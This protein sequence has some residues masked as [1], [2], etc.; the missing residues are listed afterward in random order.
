MQYML[1]IYENEG[2]WERLS[3]DQREARTGAY[4]AFAESIVKSGQ[5]KA[6]SRLGLSA[7]ATTVRVQD[8]RTLT[9]D[10]PYAE[11]KEQLGGYFL[12]EAEDLDAAIGLA[13]RLPGARSGA[14]E[15]RPLWAGGQD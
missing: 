14:I 13:A 2:E 7:S 5:Y 11:T 1:L 15:V 8:G 3:P 4:M 9:T 10:G 6:G 12:V